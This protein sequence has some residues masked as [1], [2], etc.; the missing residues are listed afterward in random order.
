VATHGLNLTVAQNYYAIVSAQRP[1]SNAQTTLQEA[2]HTDVVESQLPVRQRERDV[3]DAQLA[4]EKAKVGLA[5]LQKAALL[6][7]CPEVQARATETAPISGPHASACS[8]PVPASVC[9]LRLS[10][11]SGFRLVLWH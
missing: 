10:A 6:P 11:L 8:K 1:V 9:A 5:D 4:V 2:A 3:Q 7:P